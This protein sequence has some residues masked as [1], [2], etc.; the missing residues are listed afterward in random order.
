MKSKLF[1]ILLIP[2]LFSLTACEEFVN[3]NGIPKK[4]ETSETDQNQIG[5]NGQKEDFIDVFDDGE[6]NETEPNNNEGNNTENN[7][8]NN[9]NNGGNTEP[10]EEHTDPVVLSSISIRI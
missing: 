4:D 5:N 6:N 9:D 3:G 1:S 7:N 2:L 8:D 10:P